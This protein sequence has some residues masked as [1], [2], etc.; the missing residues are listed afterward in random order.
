MNKCHKFGMVENDPHAGL[1]ETDYQKQIIYKIYAPKCRN[2]KTDWVENIP[3]GFWKSRQ[4]VCFMTIIKLN[5]Y[6][7]GLQMTH[8][9]VNRDSF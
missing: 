8:F 7:C 2:Q 4:L 9:F 6:L 3:M 1:Q 5:V